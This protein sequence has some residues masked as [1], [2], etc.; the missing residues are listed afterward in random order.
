MKQVNR[1]LISLT[2][3]LCVFVAMADKRMAMR[4]ADTR[5][6]YE[7]AVPEGPRNH[8]YNE[9]WLDSIPYLKEHARHGESWAY[10]ALADCYRFGKGGVKR[11]FFLSL[12]FYELAG[13]DAKDVVEEIRVIDNDDPYVIFARMNDYIERSDS[14]NIVCAIDT[15]HE[16]GYHS[17]D[18]L[19][20]FINGKD[21]VVT[22]Q[23]IIEYIMDKNTDADACIFA[24][25]GLVLSEQKDSTKIE[26]DWALPLLL[27]K[28][29]YFYSLAGMKAYG[30]TV[31]SD[32]NNGYGEDATEKDVNDRRKAVEYL[33]K[34]DEQA[35]LTKRG[36][37]LLY[38]Y[39][40]MDSTSDWV[41]MTD[42][43]LHRIGVIAGAL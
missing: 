35:M 40:V 42:E 6:S 13:K 12:C 39:C 2:L 15:L 43:D 16:S 3:V 14:T 24:A 11:S 9:T 19:L 21:N 18:I 7:A 4:N 26:M 41:H 33:I 27:E 23:E 22:K 25:G 17:A 5:E 37:R 10:E 28:V 8:D 31:K 32:E 29:P 20:R 38:Y 34:A 36:A 30:H 1:L